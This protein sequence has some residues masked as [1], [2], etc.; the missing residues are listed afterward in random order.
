[1]LI[2][3]GRL[4]H[5]SGGT[6]QRNKAAGFKLGMVSSSKQQVAFPRL[7]SRL[8]G[9]TGSNPGRQP[10]Q[11]SHLTLG[12]SPVCCSVAALLKSPAYSGKEAARF[13]PCQ[14]GRHGQLLRTARGLPLLLLALQQWEKR[15]RVWETYTEEMLNFPPFPQNMRSGE[16]K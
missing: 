6:F 12:W 8:S 10:C 9:T 5:S 7:T 4:F 2:Q 3:H 13:I 16:R 15:I 14:W 1:M 11:V